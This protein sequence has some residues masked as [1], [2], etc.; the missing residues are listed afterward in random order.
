MRKAMERWLSEGA[1]RWSPETLDKYRRAINDLIGWLDR[2]NLSDLRRIRLEDLAAWL[3]SHSTWGPG[4]KHIAVYACKGFLFWALG[5]GSPAS[6]LRSP[7]R[8]GSTPPQRRLSQDQV[9][10][11]IGA[12]DTSTPKGIRDL[13]I[14]LIMLDRG[15]RASEV[16]KAR[17]DRVD[18]ERHELAVIVKGGRWSRRTF[19]DYTWSALLRWLSIR[20]SFA[21]PAA[22]TIFV[23]LGGLTR[24]WT[25]TRSG[26]LAAF[27]VMAKRAG[28][29]RLSPHDLR[30]TFVGL[31]TE[32][33]NSTKITQ[34]G[35][36]WQSISELDTYARGLVLEDWRKYSPA[37]RLMGLR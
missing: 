36:D 32:Y 18:F 28:I 20:P 26:L 7:R 30:R 14:V 33:G 12:I 3:D 31:S 35:G 25:L 34:I 8:K 22:A 4:H 19:G 9:L 23:S 21:D 37:D 13:A 10:R 29:G 15:L 17:L 1:R 24:G 6:G 5:E 2:H 27:R 11:L 16:I